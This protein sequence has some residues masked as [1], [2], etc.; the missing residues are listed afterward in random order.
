MRSPSAAGWRLAA[1]VMALVAL[2]GCSAAPVTGEADVLQYKGGPGRTGEAGASIAGEPAILWTVETDGAVDSSPAVR[3]GVAYVVGGDGRVLAIDVASGATRWTSSEGAYVGSPAIE[4]DR[5]L[6]LGADG[7]IS[8]LDTSGTVAWSTASDLEELSAPLV[9]GDTVVSGGTGGAIRGFDVA[10]GTERWS[11]QT[12]DELPRAAAGAGTI[13]F[14]GSHDGSLYAIDATDGSSVW[15]TDV[16]AVHFATPAVRD[17]SVYAMATGPD[18]VHLLAIDAATGEERWR[19]TPPD[20]RGM[21]SPSAD[22]A[23]VYISS[24]EHVYALSP[25]DG[26]IVWEHERQGWNGA[27]LT[28]T[29]DTVYSIVEGGTLY[30]LDTETGDERWHLWVGG[31]VPTGT[32]LGEGRIIVGNRRGEIVAIGGAGS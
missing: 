29:P 9:L 16:G 2:G 25:A 14:I 27:G 12:G 22:A 10:S 23:R 24:D 31:D 5:I 8:A 4:G 32:T 1:A 19:F 17:G 26:T 11:V 3:D 28:V 6:T 7:S 13:A 18:W 15:T 21:H 20:G 30:A